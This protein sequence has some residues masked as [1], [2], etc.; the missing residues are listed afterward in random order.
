MNAAL[1]AEGAVVG[2]LADSLVR[3]AND[4]DVRRAISDEQLCLVTPYVPTAPFSAG[5]AM[6]RNKL[7]Y[8]LADVTFVVASDE[9]KGGTWSGATEA[10][11]KSYGDV[12]V[13]TGEGAGPGNAAL[14][15]AGARPVES[16]DDL[17]PTGEPSST[18]SDRQLGLGI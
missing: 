15:R 11:K 3:S 14:V 10:L 1:E 9:G 8:A 7:I 16:I 12:A 5:N 2:V 4:S 13:W 17:E 18:A 6:G